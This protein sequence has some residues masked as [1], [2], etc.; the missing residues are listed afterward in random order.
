M[1]Y[2][3]INSPWVGDASQFYLICVN[4]SL[5]FLLGDTNVF[6]SA[7]VGDFTLNLALLDN[8]EIFNCRV[9]IFLKDCCPFRRNSVFFPLT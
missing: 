4:D 7:V 3:K 6:S 2:N 5:Q 1:P 8:L 9:P